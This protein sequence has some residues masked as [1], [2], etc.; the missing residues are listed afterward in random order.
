VAVK[1]EGGADAGEEKEKEKER[2]KEKAK[3]EA[4][5]AGPDTRVLH[6]NGVPTKHGVRVVLL[7]VCY[8]IVQC[9]VCC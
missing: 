3:A 6:V 5:K 9:S 2:E 1:E 4:A 8:A 7:Q